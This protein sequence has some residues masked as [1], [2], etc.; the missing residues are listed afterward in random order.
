MGRTLLLVGLSGAAL[1]AGCSNPNLSGG[2]LHF[3]Q[4]RYDRARETFAVAVEQLPQ[5]GEARLCLGKSYAELGQPDSAA[6]WFDEAAR[7]DPRMAADVKNTRDHYWSERFNSG[8][9]F[10][11]TAAEKMNQGDEAGAGAEYRSSL[12]EFQRAAVYSPDKHDTYTNIGK[13]YFNLARIDSALIVFAQVHEMAPDDLQTNNLLVSIYMD[14]G[15]KLFT[16]ASEAIAQ[17]DTT[18]AQKQYVE[19]GELYAK[20]YEI[21][22]DDPDLLFQIGSTAYELSY[23]DHKEKASYLAKAADF[24]DQV[25]KINAQDLDVLYNLALV[26]REVNRLQEAKDLAARLVDLKPK[27]GGYRELYG[28]LCDKLGDKQALIA[29]LIFGKALR[30]GETLDAAVVKDQVSKYGTNS[31]AARRMREAGPPEEVKSFKDSTGQEYQTW[32]Y[33][34]RG[35]GYAFVNGEQKYDTHFAKVAEGQ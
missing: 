29:G 6:H 5:S 7:V 1:W 22:K 9:A 2:K 34:S 12:S 18:K 27:D 28:R 32:W 8:L 23:I 3:D 33:W 21:T 15:N 25:L 14:Q 10:A 35:V 26:Y 20:A 24:Y 30:T 19:A 13:M 17:S 16:R 31:D 11:K 4:K